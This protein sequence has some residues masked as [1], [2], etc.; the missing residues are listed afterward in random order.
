MIFFVVIVLGIGLVRLF[1]EIWSVDGE[2]RMRHRIAPEEA[3][4]G[5][6]KVNLGHFPAGETTAVLTEHLQPKHGLYE[7]MRANSIA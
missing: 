1:W 3:L 4:F 2:R 7:G 5:L 6:P